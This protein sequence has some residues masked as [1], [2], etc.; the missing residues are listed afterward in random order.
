MNKVGILYG[1]W[2]QQWE[3]DYIPYIH[4][5]KELGFDTLEINALS[6]MQMSDDEIKYF[7]DTAEEENIEILSVLG[8]PVEYDLG[9]P[10]SAVRQKGID[11]EKKYLY[12]CHKAGIKAIA[13][14]LCSSWHS[15]IEDLGITKA[16]S[17]KNSVKA[18]REIA[19]Y[20]DDL[21][22]SIN[23]E[24]V[25]RFEN[26]MLNCCAEALEYIADVNSSRLFVHL[27]TFHMN[28][29]EDSFSKA[30]HLAGNK[31]GHFHVGENNRRP[32][33]V[34]LLPWS[35]I[36]NALKEINYK[37]T[38]VME[39]FIQM[40]GPIASDI[41]VYREIMPGVDLDVEAKKSL[42]F[43]RRMLAK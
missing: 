28:I 24:V 13:G 33:G 2:S 32:P 25:N 23:L 16:E 30:I 20:A 35:E 14:I 41:G 18:M 26:Y 5:V 1:Y 7:R 19:Q 17:W 15:K 38:I 10:H 31:L 8:V 43:V 22:M 12:S 40:N 6:L 42:D 3:V 27:D 29:E 21:D 9:S 4:K 11:Y 37:K 39:P 34:G 36:F